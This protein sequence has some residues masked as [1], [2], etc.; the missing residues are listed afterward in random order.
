MG[1][2]GFETAR[3]KV[4]CPIATL[5]RFGPDRAHFRLNRRVCAVM[6]RLRMFILCSGNIRQ[7]E[8]IL[9]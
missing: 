6:R 1:A 2:I 3:Q 7:F 8:K 5:G 4:H 9:S